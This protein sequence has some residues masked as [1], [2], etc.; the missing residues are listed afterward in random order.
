MRVSSAMT[1]VTA[2]L[3]AGAATAAPATAAPPPDTATTAFSVLPPGNGDVWGPTSDHRADQIRLYDGLE[4]A[5]AAGSLGAPGTAAP[6][7]KHAGFTPAEVRREERPAPGVLIQW[8]A[9]GVPYIS[10]SDIGGASFGSGWAMAEA[11]LSLLEALRAL[12]RGGVVESITSTG[13]P[14]GGARPQINYTDE[15]LQSGID[16]L[17]ARAGE[18]EADLRAGLNGY[19]DGINAWLE[20]NRTRIPWNVQLPFGQGRLADPKPWKPVDVAAAAVV[21]NDVFGVG[22]GGELGAARTLRTLRDR[23]GDTAGMALYEDL[24][25]PDPGATTHAPTPNAYPKF[26]GG[27]GDAPTGDP[28]PIDPASIAMPD[29]DT[30]VTE[31]DMP[32]KPG[33][34]NYVVLGGER[35]AT[36]HPLLIG[37]PQ[38]GYW[39]PEIVMEQVL[40]TDE[41]QA[42]GIAVPGLGPILI[43]GRTPEYAWTPTSGGTD[44]TDVRAEKLCEPDGS[45]PSRASR[46]YVFQGECRAMERRDGAPANTAWR[47][48]HGPV[49]S[50]GT[51]GGAP[52]AFAYQRQ[53]RTSTPVS[54]LGFYRM[55]I[56]RTKTAEDFVDAARNIT[57][58][59]NLGYANARD[60]AYAHTGRYPVRAPGTRPDLP[61]WGT[62]EWEWRGTLDPREQPADIRPAAGYTLSWNNIPAPGWA[63]EGWWGGNVRH[64]ADALADR[65]KDAT[66]VTVDEAVK[67]HQDAATEDVEAVALVRAAERILGDSPAPTSAA[68]RARRMLRDWVAA[69][70]HR[71]DANRDWQVD[72]AA[73]VL[74]EPFTG[75]LLDRTYVAMLGDETVRRI[76]VSED[77]P[78]V[79]G[80]A[81]QHGWFSPL[82]R[83][84]DRAAG[85]VDAPAEVPAA[86]GGGD[87]EA[88][89]AIVWDA[90]DAAYGRARRSQPWWLRNSPT[91]WRTASAAILFIPVLTL[92]T[93]M[94]WQNR[95]TFEQVSSFGAG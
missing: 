26:A 25:R 74:V 61:I 36:G 38:M 10:A 53:D 57:L 5:A 35:T 72:Q 28:G 85:V 14:G 3:A 86:C 49:L 69:G 13:L 43:A 71:R 40:R 39:S 83:E 93:P 4:T 46:H 22:G 58:S 65:F 75:A 79:T 12:G 15:D 62:G 16:E 94:R 34:S 56:G 64:R 27:P 44:A 70:A 1:M 47:T 42:R 63:G 60:I 2:V 45:A 54:A 8:D 50:W 87:A 84:L 76:P 68:D 88:C 33:M 29:A 90:L 73:A 59:L 21:I 80:S 30:P 66:N 52:V 67:G 37:G 31:A 20:A 77:R 7:Y 9:H 41:F 23:L 18:D 78:S 91:R 32:R 11:R 19:V 24:R 51:V 82:A 48:V 92:P 6:W 17:Y 81:Y 55:Q 89:R 95:P